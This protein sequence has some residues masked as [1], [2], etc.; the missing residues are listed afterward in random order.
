LNEFYQ[1]VK[2]VFEKKIIYLNNKL[3]QEKYFRDDVIKNELSSTEL[4]LRKLSKEFALI[5]H[6]SMTSFKNHVSALHKNTLENF[7]F[8]VDI[9][10]L[11]Y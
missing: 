1:E 11:T 3:P 9:K 2:F 7:Y 4:V 5:M 10:G 6:C 8:P